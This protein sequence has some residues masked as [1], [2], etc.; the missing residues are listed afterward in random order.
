M[1]V[2]VDLYDRRPEGIAV[3]LVDCVIRI[4]DYCNHAGIDLDEMIKIKHKY[5]K[6]RPYKHGGNVI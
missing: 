6:G 5:N 1:G 2:I 3:E 4:M